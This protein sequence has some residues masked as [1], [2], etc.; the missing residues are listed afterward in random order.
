MPDHAFV[1]YGVAGLPLKGG[2]GWGVNRIP[3]NKD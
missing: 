3:L 2:R 1:T